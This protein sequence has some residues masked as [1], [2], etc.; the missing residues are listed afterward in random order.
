MKTFWIL[1]LATLMAIVVGAD[2]TPK[3]EN[4]IKQVDPEIT[5]IYFHRAKRCSSCRNAEKMSIEAVKKAFP[6]QFESG[7]IDVK[8]VSVDGEPEEKKMAKEY[9]AF[10]PSLYLSVSNGEGE[11]KKITLDKMW[12]KIREGE[13]AYQSYVAESIRE[14]MK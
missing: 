6:S 4:K 12:Q 14:Q 2:S 9:G 1:L 11:N 7:E 10:G 5:L 13:K 8:S 3:K